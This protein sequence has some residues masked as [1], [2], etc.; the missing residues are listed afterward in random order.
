MSITVISNSDSKSTEAVDGNLADL[1]SKKESEDEI[2]ESASSE[3]DDESKD[4]SETSESE[5]NESEENEKHIEKPKK[6]GGF[7]R[8]INKLNAKLSAKE[9]EADYWRQEAEKAKGQSVPNQKKVNQYDESISAKPKPDDFES[10]EEYVDALTDWKV[11]NKIADY[12]HKKRLENARDEVQTKVKTHAER[13]KA[14]VSKHDDFHDLM[15]EVDDV[16][17]SGAVQEIILD[18]ENGPALM[19]ELAKN[20]DEFERICAMTPLKAAKALGQFEAKLISSK[21]KKE[22]IK[23]SKAPAPPTPI[24][25]Q[26]KKATAKSIYDRDISQAEYEA[27]RRKQLSK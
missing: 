15:E 24:R 27:L 22:P 10:H 3:V 7:Q 16:K 17:V 25:S 12:E 26:S 20:R 18:S 9:Q 21:D 6:Q 14:F 8:R 1:A 13:V 19:Y 23:H 2:N 11:E 4:E 5:E